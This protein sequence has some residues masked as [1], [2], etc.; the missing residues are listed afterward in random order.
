MVSHTIS[1]HV[2]KCTCQTLHCEWDLVQDHTAGHNGMSYSSANQLNNRRRGS[3]I[4]PSRTP[5]GRTTRDQSKPNTS[6]AEVLRWSSPFQSSI[7]FSYPGGKWANIRMKKTANDFFEARYRGNSQ[8]WRVL[9]GTFKLPCWPDRPW[10]PLWCTHS[11][12]MSRGVAQWL[13]QSPS[14]NPTM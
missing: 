4:C 5:T 13:H 11:L 10:W 9:F 2:T 7:F 8:R 6:N 14:S 3:E 12:Y 1:I